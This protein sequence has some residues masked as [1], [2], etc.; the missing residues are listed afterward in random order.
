VKLA[1]RT[2]PLVLLASSVALAAENACPKPPV[3]TADAAICL[4]Q[5]HIGSTA[6]RTYTVKYQAE[7]HQDHWSVTFGPRE[8]NVLGSGGKLRIE[9]VTGRVVFVEGYR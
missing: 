7:E 2:I 8:S 5:V 1:L 6:S 9:K 4:A 3:V